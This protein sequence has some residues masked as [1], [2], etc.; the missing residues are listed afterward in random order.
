MKFKCR[1]QNTTKTKQ[2][3]R[4]GGREMDWMS[5]AYIV[6][7]DQ[8]TTPA[9]RLITILVMVSLSDN[10]DDHSSCFIHTV[11]YFFILS[12]RLNILL[13]GTTPL[14]FHMVNVCLHCAVTGLLMHMCKCCVFEDSRSAFITA[15]LFAVH[16]VHTEAVSIWHTLGQVSLKTRNIDVKQL[17]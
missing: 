13:G 10:Q 16:P 12:F 4:Q 1:H 17:Q 5:S 7:P 6:Q 3:G 11:D 14:Y 2:C 8:V 15:L 9:Q